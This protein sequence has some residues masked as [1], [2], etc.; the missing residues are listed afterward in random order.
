MFLRKKDISLFVRKKKK[1][2]G[3]FFLFQR[4]AYMS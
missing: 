3:D 1:I 2:E 4:E